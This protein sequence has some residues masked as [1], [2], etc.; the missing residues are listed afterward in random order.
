[1]RYNL[2][3]EPDGIAITYVI[4]DN[5]IEL[6][7]E[8]PFDGGFKDARLLFPDM[9]VIE[10]HAISDDEL[11]DVIEQIKSFELTET[12]LKEEVVYANLIRVS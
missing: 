9:T 10:K 12:D 2:Y 4:N 6:Y 8:I 3:S 1:M 7:V 11:T 5:K